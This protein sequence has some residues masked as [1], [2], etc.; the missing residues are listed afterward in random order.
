MDEDTADEARV[1]AQGEDGV[2]PADLTGENNPFDEVVTHWEAV[3]EDMHATAREYREA[4]WETVALHPGDVHVLREESDRDGLD[5]VVPGD[6]FAALRELVADRSFDSYELYRADAGSMV[7]G[8]VVLE[9]AGDDSAVLV[10]VYYEVD[11]LERLAGTDSLYTH[12]RP[13]SREEIVTFTHQD[14]SPFFPST[15]EE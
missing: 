13:L 10:P 15:D 8:L 7:Y 1:D 11:E 14:P 6:E 3:V 12:V 2:D 4:G 9:A 5:V